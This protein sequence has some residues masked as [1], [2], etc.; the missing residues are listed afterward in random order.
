MIRSVLLITMLFPLQAF[1]GTGRIVILNN[2]GAN[3]GLNDPTPATPVGGN[4]GTTLGQQRLNVYLAA[5]ERWQNHLDT[6]VDIRVRASFAAISTCT[7][8]EGVLGQASPIHW[9]HSFENAPKTNVWYPIALANKFANRDLAPAVDDINVRFNASVDNATCLGATNWYYGLDNNHGDHIDLFVVVL[10]EL[11]H[12]LGIAGA[13]GAP[14]FRDNVNGTPLPSIADTH[15]YDV[16]TGLRWDQM[17][18]EQRQISFVN[19]GNLVW[20]GDQVRNAARSFLQATTTLSVSS[21]ASAAGNY[22][23]GTAAFGPSASSSVVA[24]SVAL[25]NDAAN[26]DGPAPTDGCTAFSNAAAIAGRI[27]L[28]DR[29]SCTFVTKAR[30]AQAAGAIGVVIADNTRT[31]CAPPGMAG[32]ASD[33]TIPV[34]SI[35][36][37]DA[38]LLKAQ[39][40]S[41][42]TVQASL[43]LDPSQLAGTKQGLVRLYAPCTFEPGSSIRHWDTNASPDLLME[44]S[45][46]SDLLHGVDLTIHQLLDIGW[47]LPPRTGR[48]ILKR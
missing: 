12:G 23:I 46:S 39:L 36:Q 35:T 47:S 7:D 32:V 17:S 19:T 31:T 11:G 27:A 6:N 24:G 1:A 2:D 22:D 9:E 34:I 45:I 15:T 29:G 38:D 8:T 14:G 25:V 10:H 3:V 16:S 42:A 40:S 44:P 48:R 41:G 18:L 20:D 5:A 21:P 30:N 33:V 26:T 13:A 4:T 43:R 37:N 28:I